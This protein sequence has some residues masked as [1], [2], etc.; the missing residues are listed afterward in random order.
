MKMGSFSQSFSISQ[1][2]I[3]YY[4]NSGLLCP[5][6]K[7]ARYDF[8][9]KDIEDMELLLRLKSYRFSLADIH[10]IMSLKR[11]S[12]FDDPTDLNN[13]IEILIAK[14]KELLEEKHQIEETISAVE[15]EIARVS[16]HQCNVSK[17]RTGLPLSFLEYLACPKCT[18]SLNWTGCCI[19]NGQILSGT[20]ECSCGFSA[21]VQNGILIGSPGKISKY[22]WPDIERNSYRFMN[23]R[24]VSYMQNAYHWIL[25]RLAL[26]VKDNSLVLEDFINDYCF[27]QA[28]IK[29]MNSNAKYIITDK[30][31]EIV[32]L[33]KRLIDNL[34]LDR[35]ILYIAA[36]SES[37]PLK[38]GCVDVYIDFDSSN[39]CSLFNN[40]YSTDVI[41]K[42]L[43]KD[44][45]AVGAFFSFMHGSESL[46]N[47]HKIFP[48]TWDKS[49]D[50]KYFR[51]YIYS[52]WEE[53][54]NHEVIGEVMNEKGNEKT[55]LYHIPGNVELDV[56]F[57]FGPKNMRINS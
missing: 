10:R 45:H 16:A 52:T 47:L 4:V 13:F 37:L 54:I 35:Q 24:M 28:N 44:S 36:A 56:Y 31:P 25:E 32:A 6:V 2:T 30:Y 15:N 21:S 17:R 22:D 51:E 26:C 5:S 40:C 41:A 7:N 14:K 39:E 29:D 33:Y 3:R 34:K 46:K 18:E 19:E 57:A 43:K 1:Q 8:S 55:T 27:C 11:F 53:V 12:G 42:Y 20:L 38:R 48:E 49:Y 50:K 23:P 9:K